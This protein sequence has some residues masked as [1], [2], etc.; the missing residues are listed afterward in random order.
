MLA[1]THALQ[2]ERWKGTAP[3]IFGDDVNVLPRKQ[4]IPNP[5]RQSMAVWVP[6]WGAYECVRA[7]VRACMCVH[8]R[9]YV[10]VIIRRTI[11]YAFTR[12]T[13]DAIG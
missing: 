6:M 8:L 7:C 1:F 3:A 13:Y 9:A 2:G 4:C 11:H 5:T 12:L 10:C